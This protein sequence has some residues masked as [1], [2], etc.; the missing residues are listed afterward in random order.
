[1][2][3]AQ[4]LYGLQYPSAIVDVIFFLVTQKWLAPR[5]KAFSPRTRKEPIKGVRATDKVNGKFF[6]FGNGNADVFNTTM[7]EIS[8][9]CFVAQAIPIIPPQSCIIRVIFLRPIVE[10]IFSFGYDYEEQRKLEESVVNALIEIDT[11]AV[12][13]FIEAFKE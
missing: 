1:M 2:R 4:E 9:V 5:T 3:F 13:P 10:M 8:E 7:R 6:L 11:L 12:Y